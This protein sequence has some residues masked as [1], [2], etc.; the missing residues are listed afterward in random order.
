MGVRV[1]SGFESRQG[2]HSCFPRTEAGPGTHGGGRSGPSGRVLRRRWVPGTE[3][4]ASATEE[5]TG[6]SLNP[7]SFPPLLICGLWGRSVC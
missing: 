6:A 5:E 2:S 1:V 4:L 3:D 7:Q